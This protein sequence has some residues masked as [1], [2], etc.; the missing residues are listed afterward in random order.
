MKKLLRFERAFF[1]WFPFSQSLRKFSL[2]RT[3]CNEGGGK[4]V[5]TGTLE[6]LIIQC[7]EIHANLLP[8]VIDAKQ[9]PTRGLI[10]GTLIS[11]PPPIAG[12]KKKI[13]SFEIFKLFMRGGGKI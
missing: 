5:Q 4:G 3:S 1:L 6:S 8:V 9:A 2:C 13:S 12:R 7:I 10:I 11:P